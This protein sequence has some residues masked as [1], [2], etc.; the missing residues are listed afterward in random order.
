[1]GAEQ[2]HVVLTFL[3]YTERQQIDVDGMV[4]LLSDEISYTN[5]VPSTPHVGRDAVRAE[6][7]RHQVLATGLL[8]GSE[9]RNITSDDRVVFVERVEVTDMRAR[10][11]AL[12]ITGVFEVD[13]GKIVAW[14]DYFDMADVASQLGIDVRDIP[15]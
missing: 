8:A 1:M 10:R 6:L 4:G 3:K 2:E 5:G 7:E 15:R 13:G 14:R 9:I 11:L 12:H